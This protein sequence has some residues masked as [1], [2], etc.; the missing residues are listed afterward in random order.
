MFFWKFALRNF[1]KRWQVS[2]LLVLGA[3]IPSLLTVSSL[4]LNDSIV[5]YRK[6]QVEV[7]FGQADAFI[8]NNR[9]SLFFS[10]PLSQMILD[11][12]K[13]DPK[14]KNI[15][16][17]SES[18]GRIEHNGRF[19]E[20][21]VVAVKGEDLSNFVGQNIDISP[22]KVVVS[23]EIA[24]ESGIDEGETIIIHM[25]GGS[26]NLEISHVGENGFLNY[27]G[28]M[29]QYPGSVFVN[30]SDFEGNTV[31]PSKAYVDFVESEN[32]HI[33]DI[34]IPSNLQIINI[35]EDFLNSPANEILG[36]IVLAF[37]FFS[38]MAGLIL[39]IVFGNNFANEQE[40]TVGILRILGFKRGKILFLFFMEALLYFG[41][42]SLIGVVLGAKI[43]AVLL[44]QLGEIASGLTFETLGSFTIAPYE[45]SLQTIILGFLIGI[46]IPL[47]IFMIKGLHIS[48]NSPVESLKKD[49][50]AYVP[51]GING[52][53]SILFI[54]SGFLLISFANEFEILGLILISLGLVFVLKNPLFNVGLSIFLM[55][56]S[57]TYFSLSSG[58][59]AFNFIF[60]RA[61]LFGV[62]VVLFFTSVIPIL[63]RFSKVFS[64]KKS[65]PFLLGFSYVERFPVRVLMLSLMFGIIIFGLIVISSIPTNL[66]KFIDTSTSDGLF[67]YNFLVVSNPIKNLFFSDDIE[68]CDGIEKPTKV[69]VAMLDSQIIAFV[70]NTFLESAIIPSESVT[71]WREELKNKN[72]VL[73]AK[74]SDEEKVPEYVKGNLSSITPLGGESNVSYDVVGFFNLKDI[75]IPV[76][77]VANIISKPNSVK[78]I[79]I[80]LGNVPKENIDEVKQ[81]YMST[82]DFPIFIEEE[83]QNIYNG[84]DGIISLATGMLYLGLISGFSGLALYSVRS[85]I[86]RQR[87]IGTLRAIGSSSKD[88]TKGLLIENFSIVSVGAFIGLVG[89]YLVAKDIVFAIFQFLGNVD[90]Y[91]PLL[92][93]IGI[94][95]MVYLVTFLTLMIP[96]F[97]ITKITPADSLREI[98]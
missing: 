1:L 72:A 80:L 65:V 16:P 6:T 85:C 89:G 50:E 38:I 97:L 75:T 31:F 70:D 45:L 34:P 53:F 78:S 52:W 91:F 28:E 92:N 5:S 76:K 63:K 74:F 37:S 47:L 17:V 83:L 27:R 29:A 61:F 87:I 94:V 7:N 88:I 62:I 56:L 19:L 81:K 98:G 69:Q 54:I 20:V 2:I 21:L 55:I 57:K 39:V 86:I 8:V 15:L 25:P 30:V 58:V 84:V 33:S 43:G 32:V 12:I 66:V 11:D 93:V 48:N 95:G 42:S 64:S 4:S 82:F 59:L 9:T 90:F 35:K 71:D 24:K 60:Q 26:K 96:S 3:I 51:H 10:F 14:I 49:V 40:K 36:Y 18:L 22:G 77:Y 41:I 46:I 79:D 44:N 68:V 23:K 13:S 67:G 73:Y